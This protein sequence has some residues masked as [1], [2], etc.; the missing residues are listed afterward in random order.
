[1]ANLVYKRV[2]TDRGSRI[3][4]SSAGAHP[5]GAGIPV[6]GPAPVSAMTRRH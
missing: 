2:S 1:M 3:S 4:S 5:A 6:T